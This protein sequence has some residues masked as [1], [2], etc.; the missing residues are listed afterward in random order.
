[1]AVEICINLFHRFPD[2]R[3]ARHVIGSGAH[4]L[5]LA[6]AVIDIP[7]LCRRRNVKHADALGA[8]D[9]VPRKSQ[10]INAHPFRINPVFAV[11]LHRIHMEQ[12]LGIDHFHNLRNLLNGLHG[13]DLIVHKHHRHENGFRR[14]GRPQ[15]IQLHNA[16]VIH[17]QV[18]HRKALGFQIFHRLQ[19][20]R[21]LDLCRDQ[22][23][24]GPLIGHGRA[25]QRQ[26]V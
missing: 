6:A 5:L 3:N 21:M 24:P 15:G 19:H 18:G 12:R 17:R 14:H 26:I 10:Q 16:V 22:V 2:T 11:G 4:P 20:R 23:L 25:D 7:H 8:V 1:M 13:T 9:L